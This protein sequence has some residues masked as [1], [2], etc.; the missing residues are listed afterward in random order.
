MNPV[1]NNIYVSNIGDN[2]IS[3]IDAR[4]NI[5]LDEI[6]L[7]H[8]TQNIGKNAD[9]ILNLPVKVQFPLVASHVSV[10]IEKNLIYVTNTASNAVTIIDGKTDSVVVRIDFKVNPEN[11]GT[12]ECNNIRVEPEKS[13]L[14]SKDSNSS[15]VAIPASGFAFDYWSDSIASTANPVSFNV[16]GFDGITANFKSTLSLEQ[17]LFLILGSIGTT[18]ILAGV[19]YRR[20]ERRYL[21]RYMNR[22]DSTYDNLNE[23]N[24][25]ECIRQIENI[26]REI[27]E[28]FKKGTIND[29]HY[30]ILDKKIFEYLQ[31]LYQQS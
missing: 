24:R 21:K 7:N 2:T 6:S 31:K 30:N 18:S 25:L 5:K 10:N 3:I 17:Y 20:R 11:A 4:R 12:I 13:Y 26:R 16:R 29:S 27:T 9:P 23:S 22:I 1:S 14:F 8:N 28:S 15:C 19:Y